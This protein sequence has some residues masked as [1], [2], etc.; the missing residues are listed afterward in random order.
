MFDWLSGVLTLVALALLAVMSPALQAYG[1]KHKVSHSGVHQSI[2]SNTIIARAKTWLNPPVPYSE[3]NTHN[4]YRTD[5]SG[6][7]SMA[8]ELSTP[9]LTTYTLGTVSHQISPNDLQPG[10][11]LLNADGGGNPNLAHVV[12]FNGWANP[13]HTYY[14]AYEQTPPH[15]VYHQLPYPYWPGDDPQGYVPMRYNGFTSSYMVG[16]ASTADGK[17]YWLVGN[18]GGVFSYGDAHFYGSMGGKHINAPIVGMA[19]TPDAHGYW[20]VGSDGGIFTFGDATF[21]GSTGT[22]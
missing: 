4:G 17:G 14:W 13:Q 10:D 3:Y 15:T 20:L 7:V 2:T 8:W 12:I 18:D 5:C 16:M 21:Y 11:V 9:G 1:G 19:A 6:Y 22:T